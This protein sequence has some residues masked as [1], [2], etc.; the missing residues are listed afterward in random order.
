MYNHKDFF[1]FYDPNYICVR[2]PYRHTVPP[3]PPQYGPQNGPQ[4]VPQGGP[5]SAPPN[6]VPPQPKMQQFGAS[7]M[8]VDPGT[9]RPCVYKYVYIWPRRGH[10][11]WA[12]I[13][14]VRRRSISGYRWSGN[15]WRYFGMDL[16][17]IRSFQCF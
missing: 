1:N 7:P 13:T 15:R 14:D 12:W 17:E 8:A 11:F 4:N 2:C 10:G 6:F 3:P 9:I 5:S 16:R